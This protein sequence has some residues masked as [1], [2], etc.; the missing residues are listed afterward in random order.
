MTDRLGEISG[1]RP[2]RCRVAASH[3]TDGPAAH[4]PRSG[5]EATL[6]NGHA[7]VGGA[8]RNPTRAAPPADAERQDASAVGFVLHVGLHGASSNALRHAVVEVAD[9]LRELA[10]D[11]L[12]AAE[13]F[14]AV[15]L[16]AGSDDA[17]TTVPDARHVMVGLEPDTAHEN[18]RHPDV[19]LRI[20]C[21]TRLVAIHGRDIHLTR[22]EFDLL[23]F[24]ARHPRRVFTRAQLLREVWEY[25]CVVC[26]RTVDAHVRRL[27]AK[28]GEEAYRITTVRGVGYRLDAARHEQ[29]LVDAVSPVA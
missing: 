4:P 24:L 23:A 6:S 12:P 2:S 29:L 14:V 21:S 10:Q 18:E 20:D 27:R 19:G 25:E 9:A 7:Y 11:A 26:T 1:H 3:R 16:S 8:P 28:L 5:A 15:T 17:V 22:R 13:T